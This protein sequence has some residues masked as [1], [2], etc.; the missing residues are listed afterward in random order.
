MLGLEAGLSA[1]PDPSVPSGP[2]LGL[3]KQMRLSTDGPSLAR[4]LQQK[5]ERQIGPMDIEKFVVQLGDN[6]L[7]KREDASTK[8]AAVGLAALPTLRQAL[9]HS[10]QEVSRRASVLIE[11][12]S[13][14]S[15]WI[16]TSA[17]ARVLAA[18]RTQE[19][20]ESLLKVLPYIDTDESA[21]VAIY[22]GLYEYANR[23]REFWPIL[24][25]Y[26]KDPLA[27]RR[28][29]AACILGCV[30]GA[31]ERNAVRDLLND[32]SA[33]VRLRAA[34]GLL[35][36]HD[37]SGIPT[38]ID[39]LNAPPIEI[40]WQAEEL[41]HWA[42]NSCGPDTVLG[43]GD[44]ETRR[45]SQEA[46]R[47]WWEING[48][49]FDL[50]L[51]DTGPTRPRL[52]LLS[53]WNSRTEKADR[54]VLVGSSGM[55]RWKIGGLENVVDFQLVPGAK[56]LVAEE[57]SNAVSEVKLQAKNERKVILK[58]IIPHACRRLPN[59]N[60][61]VCDGERIV[62]VTMQGE[63]LHDRRL[64]TI[65]G[66]PTLW[67]SLCPN[68]LFFGCT[69]AEQP[70]FWFYN[71]FMDRLVSTIK[72]K[73]D[74][75]KSARFEPLSNGHALFVHGNELFEM[76]GA[77]DIVWRW[78]MP[79]FEISQALR[80]IQG[81][82][83]V[84]GWVGEQVPCLVE[85]GRDG[86]ILSEVVRDGG[87]Q[88]IKLCFPV[89]GVGF[90]KIPA[91][92]D[93]DSIPSRLKQLRSKE[94]AV[95]QR[96]II[97]LGARKDLTGPAVE[98]LIDQLSD[99][100]DSNSGWASWALV[101]VGPNAVPALRKA[102]GDE[103][104]KVRA[105]VVALFGKI[106]PEIGKTAI[107][108]LAKSLHDKSWQVRRNA[109]DAL[110]RFS[111]AEAE[112]IVPALLLAIKDRNYQVRVSVVRALGTYPTKANL[113][114]S[115][116]CEALQDENVQVVSWA[117]Y[118]LGLMEQG[119]K[120]AVPALVALFRKQDVERRSAALQ[121]LSSL[122][123][124]AG[125]SVALLMESVRDKGF[126]EQW[127]GILQTIGSIGPGAHQAVSGLTELLQDKAYLPLRVH[128]TEALGRI[129]KSASPGIPAI[130]DLLKTDDDELQR[131]A[132][133]A[134]GQIRDGRKAVIDTLITLLDE[135][136]HIDLRIAAA[137]ALGQ[138][139]SQ[140]TAAV[141]AL[142][143]LSEDQNAKVRKA[144]RGALVRIR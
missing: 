34:Q 37:K 109:A 120:S 88:R 1:Q 136:F 24:A 114:V 137:D 108:E 27:A 62:E 18:C 17:M 141:P 133:Y 139:G 12:L 72:I 60:T 126:K 75:P 99:A 124:H 96:A 86:K 106:R 57:G 41:L 119:G 2:D 33:L 131:A 67:A 45:R 103:R 143:R 89:L 14:D 117:A 132:V 35:A 107:P 63:F 78:S 90:D 50:S 7:E 110:G 76:N 26:L 46:W 105:E 118:S 65:D 81:E 111:E 140:A 121:A 15:S 55:P 42:T 92:R 80:P 4:L 32:S 23:D 43:M 66:K 73:G 29:V 91:I 116:L 82:T 79:H 77:G 74:V 94:A 20:A 48:A 28:A 127:P 38:L 53:E 112:N 25:K 71:L 113:T 54:I 13:K 138:I 104:E 134:L 40:G 144:A 47:K 31:P 142:T 135:K 52:L 58:D 68:G 36:Q 98:S 49:K 70:S 125:D 102:I 95:R 30:G 39:L 22:F 83:L 44:A 85:I 9:L 6:N 51:L 10:D 84:A 56:V 87:F 8:I 11:R 129:G 64:P 115:P 93:C 21:E 97:A 5:A 59:D 16:V 100:N 128:I 130:L 122:G 61:L 3:L 19:A 69:H 123:Q 101:Q